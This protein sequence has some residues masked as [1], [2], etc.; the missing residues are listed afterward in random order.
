MFTARSEIVKLAQEKLS[1]N[2]LFLDTETTGTDSKSEIVEISIIDHNGQALINTLVNPL[3]P[4]PQDSTRIHGITNAMVENAPRWPDVWPKVRA[5]LAGKHVGVYNAEFDIRMIKQTHT[6][7]FIPWSLTDI[8][9]FCIMKIYAQ[10]VGEWNSRTRSYRWHSLDS[11]GKRCGIAIPN[12][13]RALD[14]TKLAKA[15]FEFIASQ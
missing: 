3:L 6:R 10:F 13:H 14:D 1:H 2:P 5:A 9:F 7:H 12:S 11:A 8:H 4:I 15:V